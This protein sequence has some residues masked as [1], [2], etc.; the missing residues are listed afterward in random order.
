MRVVS[1]SF[2]QPLQDRLLKFR[3]NFGGAENLTKPE[4]SAYIAERTASQEKAMVA[5]SDEVMRFY[6]G[7]MRGQTRDQP[8]AALS[9]RLKAADALMKRYNVA[10]KAGGSMAV[11]DDPITA[12]LKEEFQGI[13][14]K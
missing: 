11:E 2:L 3:R 12:A 9:D 14:P 8:G 6:T 4:I 1:V 13:G 5:D 7:V 10:E